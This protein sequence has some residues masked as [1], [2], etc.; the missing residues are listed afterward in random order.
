MH[1]LFDE[2]LYRLANLFF[3]IHLVLD[4]LAFIL[5]SVILKDHSFSFP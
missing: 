3:Y 2:M 1:Q 4:D 5:F